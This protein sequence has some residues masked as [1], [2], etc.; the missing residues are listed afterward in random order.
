M[1]QAP[2]DLLQRIIAKASAARDK[3]A[4]IDDL[5]QR[6]TEARSDLT[7]ITRMELPDLLD[8]AG[9]DSIGL[10]A[11]G[12][13]PAMDIT[14]KSIYSANIAAAWS[15]ARRAEAFA[16]LEANGHGDLIKTEVTIAWP[17]ELRDKAIEFIDFFR[18][19]YVGLVPEITEAVHKQTLS[20]WF[21]QQVRNGGELPPL[22]VLGASTW[23]V[24][25]MKE[26]Q[27]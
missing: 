22:D 17:R 3:A 14:L 8:E 16:W 12:N 18:R 6:L 23:R 11:S 15:E 25:E 19:R 20:A 24:A 5:E 27:E 7:R 21:K 2:Q 10:E 26:R 1:P 13:L 9:T 4:E